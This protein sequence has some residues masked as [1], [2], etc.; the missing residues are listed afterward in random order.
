[1]QQYNFINIDMDTNNPGG[2]T[3]RFIVD[4]A[5][6]FFFQFDLITNI[7]VKPDVSPDYRFSGHSNKEP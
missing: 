2:F 1:M 4:P 3:A 5:G 7:V 6:L